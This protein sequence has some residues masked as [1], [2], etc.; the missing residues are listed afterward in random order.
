MVGLSFNASRYNFG[1]ELHQYKEYV[2]AS[3]KPPKVPSLIAISVL[4]YRYY[5]VSVS[6]YPAMVGYAR[7]GPRPSPNPRAGE[8]DRALDLERILRARQD[9]TAKS[10]ITNCYIG[11]AYQTRLAV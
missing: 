8:G 7:R 5:S 6:I 10:P 1:W 4:H 2:R 3:T 11:T 9:K